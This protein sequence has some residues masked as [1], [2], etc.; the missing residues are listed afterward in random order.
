MNFQ[1]PEDFDR[2]PVSEPPFSDDDMKAA[3]MEGADTDK[4][5]AID[6]LSEG[7][8]DAPPEPPTPYRPFPVDVLPPVLQNLAKHAASAL[9]CD[10]AAVALPALA[11]AASAIGTT[12]QLQIKSSW[13][14]P[15][16]L[17]CLLL[18][19]S[20]EKKSPAMDV[21]MWPLKRLQVECSKEFADVK[22]KHQAD[23]LRWRVDV[24]EW[25]A[26]GAMGDPPDPPE[27]PAM[28]HLFTTDPTA[29]AVAAM[30]Q[31]NPRGLLLG[32]DEL[33]GWLA[34]FD[35]YKKSK[36]AD[37][38][39]WL[40]MHRAG[41]AK[42]DR[43]GQGGSVFIPRAAVSVAGTIQPGVFARSLGAG[44]NGGEHVENGLAARL[45]I[46]APP[47]R[48]SGWTDAEVPRWVID[49]WEET[50]RSL[51]NLTPRDDDGEP[52]TLYLTD[53]A[54]E[55]F[56]DFVNEHAAERDTLPTPALRAAWAKLEGYAA[57]IAQ[58]VCLVRTDGKG[59]EV[60]AN[61][62]EAGIRIARWFGG[63]ARRVYR[64]LG[65][66]SVAERKAERERRLD[67]LFQLVASMDDGRATA[68]DIQ[69]RRRVYAADHDLLEADLEEMAR[70]RWGKYDYPP[71]TARGGHPS[72]AF[73]VVV[74]TTPADEAVVRDSDNVDAEAEGAA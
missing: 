18:A 71:T 28:R 58:V 68:R 36:G 52:Q 37:V 12:R 46:A 22:K 15:P 21:A 9:Q 30:L 13:I 54:R 72:K 47:R 11:V 51:H 59:K 74:D 31:E 50:V 65:L 69:R 19:E 27:S 44:S 2:V 8:V 4:T 40:E 5:P 64:M 41:V 26:N 34:G 67:D 23:V 3:A 55:R 33:N 43:K 25:K 17:W 35:A 24:Q 16:I 57:R 60:S 49:A 39:A 32:R 70:R 7:S 1:I 45:L 66:S 73:A 56:I 48:Q 38:S 14:E 42:V 62:M 61:D 29:E 63:E 10:P 53:A 6:P 20:G